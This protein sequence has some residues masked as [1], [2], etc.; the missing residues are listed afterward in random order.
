MTAARRALAA[1]AIVLATG[2]ALA[3]P[4]YAS[5]HASLDAREVARAV[6]RDED[7]VT[8]VEL[9]GWIR[10]RRPGL[11]VIDLRPPEA[12]DDYHVPGAERMTLDSLARDPF[13]RDE[14]VVVYSDGGTQGAQGWLLLRALGMRNVFFLRGG[15]YEWL[16]QVMNPVLPDAAPPAARQAFARTAALSRYFGGVPRVGG[17]PA[18]DESATAPA[19]APA[20]SPTRASLGARTRSRGC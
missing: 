15:M 18:P 1:G 6:A 17:L 20:S 5:A 8:A 11:R 13:R 19:S 3:G 4:P 14:T 12:F 16:E 9:A 7:H 10:D 2:A